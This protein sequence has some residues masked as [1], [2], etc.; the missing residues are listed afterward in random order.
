MACWRGS[1]IKL[2]LLIIVVAVV[3]CHPNGD[4]ARGSVRPHDRATGHLSHSGELSNVVVSSSAG[5]LELDDAAVRAVKSAGPF[6]KPPEGLVEKDNQMTFTFSFYFERGVL[7][8]KWRLPSSLS[9][10][11]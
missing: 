2:A 10:C 11:N 8:I 4:Q 1:W 7:R 5:V 9:Q 6:E 3:A